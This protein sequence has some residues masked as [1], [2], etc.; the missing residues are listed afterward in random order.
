MPRTERRPSLLRCLGHYWRIHLAV[1]LGVA[2][3]AAILTGALLIGDSVKGSLRD[4]TLERLGDIEYS[5]TSTGFFRERLASDLQAKGGARVAPAIILN[6]A[7]TH[8]E[9]RRRTSGIGVLG[10]DQRLLEL[11]PGY[12]PEFSFD[13]DRPVS[14]R[15][16]Q[17]SAVINQSLSDEL[18]AVPGDSILLSFSSK[19][20]VNPEFVLGRRES[21]DLYRTMRLK[22]ERV[23]SDRALGRFSLNPHQA[24]PNNVFVP[25]VSLQKALDQEGK[26]NTLL[27]SGANHNSSVGGLQKD[28]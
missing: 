26:G 15:I 16:S 24:V 18:K 1:T 22:V 27:V 13:L 8:A 20:A 25:L 14:G 10:I 4:L 5:L 19:A 28:F 11:Y 23:I 21:F 12:G 3:T 17:A 9:S 7:A 6:S 2:V